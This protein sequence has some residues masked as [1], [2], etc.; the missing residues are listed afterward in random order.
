MG[1]STFRVTGGTNTEIGVGTFA[2][3]QWFLFDDPTA[4]FF[5][6]NTIVDAVFEANGVGGNGTVNL[7]PYGWGTFNPGRTGTTNP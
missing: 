6:D 4:S 2:L 3:N 7:M 5:G 1:D